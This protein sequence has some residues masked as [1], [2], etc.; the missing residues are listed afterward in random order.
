MVLGVLH[1]AEQRAGL[2]RVVTLL[3]ELDVVIAPHEAHVR[4]GIDERVRVLQHA[5]AHLPRPELT[6]DLEGLVDF[7]GLGDVDV[8]VLVFRGV[9]QLGQRGVAGTGVVPAV[10]AFFGHAIQALDHF[11]RPAWLQLVQP[12]GQGRA[13]DAAADQQHIYFLGFCGVR[14]HDACSDSQTQQGLAS[15]LE[16]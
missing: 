7:D 15:F 1:R 6:G 11:H 13:H 8:A 14:L 4:S 2:Q 9:V 5:L 16:H 10:G 3:Q 12:H